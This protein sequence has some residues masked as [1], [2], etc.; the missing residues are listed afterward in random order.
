MHPTR[1]EDHVSSTTKLRR[2]LVLALAGGS[3]A[4]GVP[5]ALAAGGGDA[6]GDGGSRSGPAYQRFA[7][8]EQAAPDR[9]DCPE[10]DG[11]GSGQQDSGAS[12]EI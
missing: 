3:L 8:D 11:G 12:T 1:K 10:R 5:A 2:G 7:Q 9:R 4:I 6:A